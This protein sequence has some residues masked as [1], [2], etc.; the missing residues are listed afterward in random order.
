M[1]PLLTGGENVFLTALTMRSSRPASAPAICLALTE[2]E[3]WACLHVFCD[4]RDNG[5]VIGEMLLKNA[6]KCLLL[7]GCDSCS[8]FIRHVYIH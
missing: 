7:G 3:S 4:E 1:H 5:A 8:I 6:L 2:S